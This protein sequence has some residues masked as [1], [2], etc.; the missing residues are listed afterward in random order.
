MADKK[1]KKDLPDELRDSAHKIWLAGLGAL[2]TAEE[3][4]GKIFK[5]LVERGEKLESR[6]RDRVHKVRSKVEDAWGDVEDGFDE[7][8]T[9]VLHRLGVPSRDEIRTL[10]SRVE[11]LSAKVD[12]LKPKAAAK[13]SA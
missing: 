1:K 11:E 13:K 8:V 5:N 10:T 3:Q 2:A 4:G 7:R 6:G 12:Q 9:G